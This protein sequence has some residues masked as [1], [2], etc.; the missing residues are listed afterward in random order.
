MKRNRTLSVSILS[1]KGGVGKTNIALN[2]GYCLYKGGNSLLLM[3]CDL[4]LANLDVL[5]GLTPDKNLQDLVDSD[6]DPRDVAVP[7]EP[8]GFDFLP[9]ASGVPELFD[10]DEE[11]RL[12]LFQKMTPMFQSY[13]FLFMDLG[14]GITPSVLS[15]AAMSRVRV[16]VITGGRSRHCSLVNRMA[17]CSTLYTV[18]CAS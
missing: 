11:M 6:I 2:L 18:S 13:D 4:G 7:L 10:M 14:A 17:G 12:T 15:F 16:I 8:N 1:G 5:L 3:D 9:A